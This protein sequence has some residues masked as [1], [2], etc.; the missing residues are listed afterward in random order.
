MD[1]VVHGVTKSQTRLSNFHFPSLSL[2]MK[3]LSQSDRINTEETVSQRN[4]FSVIQKK[5]KKEYILRDSNERMNILNNTTPKQT[6]KKKKTQTTTRNVFPKT[7][8]N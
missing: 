1:C 4:I 3:T 6:N 8:H 2:E 7:M 5:K